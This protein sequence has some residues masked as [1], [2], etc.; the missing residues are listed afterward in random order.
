MLDSSGILNPA[1]EKRS[2]RGADP[3]QARNEFFHLKEGDSQG[4]TDFLNRWGL[5]QQAEV[6]FFGEA[7][8]ID[9]VWQ[10]RARFMQ[11]VMEP[12][13]EWLND[14]SVNQ[15]SL[16]FFQP[17]AKHP[18]FFFRATDCLSAIRT[19]ITLDL[20]RKKKFRRCARKDCRIPFEVRSKHR[21]KYCTQ[22]C[23]HIESVREERRKEQ[24]LKRAMA[25]AARRAPETKFEGEVKRRKYATRKD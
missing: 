17:R 11:A 16:S 10:V 13:E 4:L 2:E 5:W 9:E 20:L 15:S 21:R 24:E 8:H 6:G 1:H 22:Y 7:M 25:K 19:T 14:S 23:G 18:H 3:W 12:I